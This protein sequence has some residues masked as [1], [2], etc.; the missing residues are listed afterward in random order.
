MP[1]ADADGIREVFRRGNDRRDGA[2]GECAVA[3]F[4]AV[5]AAHASGFY[6]LEFLRKAF[7]SYVVNGLYKM[8]SENPAVIHE[9][10]LVKGNTDQGRAFYASVAV[11]VGAK[12]H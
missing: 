9:F 4:A 8:A 1:A 6:S 11:N 5:H 12:H 10:T 7:P 2:F 3:D